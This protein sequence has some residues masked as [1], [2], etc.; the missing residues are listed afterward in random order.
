MLVYPDDVNSDLVAEAQYF[1]SYIKVNT[2]S[3]NL[4]EA[5]L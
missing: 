2:I 1:H 3:D 5:L 4:D